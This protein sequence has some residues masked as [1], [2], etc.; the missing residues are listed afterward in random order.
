MNTTNYEL[1]DDQELVESGAYQVFGNQFVTQSAYG[2]QESCGFQIQGDQFALEDEYG[3]T[4][5]FT[6]VR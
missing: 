1:Y 2:E 6:R 4:Y 3:D 5:I